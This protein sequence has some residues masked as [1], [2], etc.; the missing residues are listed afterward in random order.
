MC[1]TTSGT[2]HHFGSIHRVSICEYCVI[3]KPG[4]RM[5]ISDE[6]VR[7]D[8]DLYL[9]VGQDVASAV[10]GAV[11]APML[12]VA[13]QGRGVPFDCYPHGCPCGY[14]THPTRDC[15]R[16]TT[17]ITRYQKRTSGPLLDRI[18]IHLDVP[19]IE[20]EKLADTRAG[21]RCTADYQ[22]PRPLSW[23]RCLIMAPNPPS[24]QA[25]PATR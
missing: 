6:L 19:Q 7:R 11:R 23:R 8:E 4:L 18:D 20:C 1:V 13:A 3:V 24:G 12:P 10:F 9:D 5:T 22:Q 17:S 14:L 15:P 2:W 25:S 16:S 21:A